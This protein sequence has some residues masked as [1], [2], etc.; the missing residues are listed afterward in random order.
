MSDQL[1]LV[2][3]G[4]ALGVPRVYCECGVCQ[5]ARST[6]ANRRMRCSALLRGV[7]GE[8]L[9]DCGPDWRLQ[10]ERMGLRHVE[11]VLITHG[12]HDHIAGLPDLWDSVRWTG[13]PVEVMGPEPALAEIRVRFPWAAQGLTLVE[14]T[15]GVTLLGW[16]VQTWEVNHGR[17]GR[18]FAYRFDRPDFAWAYCPDSID[19]SPAQRA[20]LSGLDLLVLGTAY[21]EES[22][23]RQ[24][25]SLYSMVEALQLLADVRPRRTLFTHLSHGVDICSRYPLPDGIS[26]GRESMVIQLGQ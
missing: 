14:F 18:S 13:R 8:L 6:G 26:V 12:H 9:I 16:E 24:R 4:D 10:M 17:N 7:Q 23:P 1:V 25:R 2:G 3:T 11:R 21:Y 22:A 19:L 15:A 20:P 5:E